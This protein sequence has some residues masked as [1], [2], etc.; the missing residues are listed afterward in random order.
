MA[1]QAE[2]KRSIR[3]RAWL[4]PCRHDSNF[5]SGPAGNHNRHFVKPRNTGAPGLA[6]F[7][8]VGTSICVY[9]CLGSREGLPT[10]LLGAKSTD[11]RRKNDMAHISSSHTRSLRAEHCSELSY[12]ITVPAESFDLERFAKAIG[13][14]VESQGWDSVARSPRDPRATDYHLHVYWRPHYQDRSKTQLQVDVHCW[15]PE[16][17]TNHGEPYAENFFDWVGQFFKD[18]SVSAHVHAEFEYPA[19]QWN[20]KIMALPITVPYQE[21]GA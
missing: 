1:S 14:S 10:P 8:R 5:D 20:S 3:I 7:L 12:R 4:Q 21:K 16:S 9:T 2:E 17:K 6:L 13:A 15:P 11:S 18:E 19:K